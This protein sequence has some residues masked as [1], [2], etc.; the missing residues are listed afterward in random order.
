MT[1]QKKW[2]NE[3]KIEGA[4]MLYKHFSG[5]K[6]N[7]H[8]PGEMDFSVII[9]DLDYARELEQQGWNINYPKPNPE[10]DPEEDKRRPTLKVKLSF[11]NENFPPKV[12]TI[13][14]DKDGNEVPRRITQDTA[15]LLDTLRFSNIDMFITP[16]HWAKNGRSGISAYLSQFYGTVEPRGFE[17]KYGF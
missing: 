9:E 5:E 10:I 13:S 15:Y 2:I 4:R 14:Y 3:I 11:D 6:D 8:A 17:G 1:E 16:Y 7:Y 12:W